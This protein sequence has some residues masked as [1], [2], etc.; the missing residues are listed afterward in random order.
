MTWQA[1][2]L[3]GAGLLVLAALFYW[4]FIIAE[5]AY[6]GARVVAWTY[7]LV[8][9]RY[10]A[11]KQFNPRD[12]SWFVARPLLRGLAGVERPLVLD[13]ATGTGRL[14]LALFRE[15]FGADGGRVIGLDFSRGMLRRARAKL[16]AYG[17]QWALIWQDA[18]HLPFD[19]G[20]FDAVVCLESLEFMPR[21]LDTLAEMVRVLAPG[22]VLFLTNRVGREARFLPGRAI[23]RPLF[24]KALADLD[25]R[26]VEVRPWQVNY[27]LAAGYKVGQ[28]ATRRPDGLDLLSL[29]RCPDCRGR[30]QHDTTG[31]SCTACNQTFSLQEGILWLARSKEQGKL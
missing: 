13:V 24:E 27:D 4:Q 5:G 14:P 18:G 25:L 29:V 10:D 17:E 30:L 7:D 19:D 8:A 6:L 1:L 23:Q 22:G 20:T 2:L 12:E 15:Q 3:A 11:V 28:Q 26:D 31:F 21:P 16:Q 9:H